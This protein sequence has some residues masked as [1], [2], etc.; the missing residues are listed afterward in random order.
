MI[1]EVLA[2]LGGSFRGVYRSFNV[3]AVREVVTVREFTTVTASVFTG[4][5]L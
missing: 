5:V 3:P 4:C 1:H 2:E